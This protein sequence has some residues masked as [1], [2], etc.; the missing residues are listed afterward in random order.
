[1][2]ITYQHPRHPPRLTAHRRARGDHQARPCRLSLRPHAVKRGSYPR[3]SC[4]QKHLCRVCDGQIFHAAQRR[5]R[6]HDVFWGAQRRGV[7]QRDT[8]G[9]CYLLSKRSQQN[10]LLFDQGE[11]FCCLNRSRRILSRLRRRR[12]PAIQRREH[13]PRRKE[14]PARAHHVYRLKASPDKLRGIHQE[15]HPGTR[16]EQ[17]VFVF[18][19]AESS[20]NRRVGF[21]FCRV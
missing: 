9:A 21:F 15:L 13:V 7:R 6:R 20:C 2:G 5:Q 18:V 16:D 8:R 19:V 4:L 1:M 3:S 17:S 11:R 12:R 14:P 10:R